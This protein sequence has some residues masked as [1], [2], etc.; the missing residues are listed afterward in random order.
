M[1]QMAHQICCKTPSPWGEMGWMHLF[2]AWQLQ[3]I[4]ATSWIVPEVLCQNTDE[5]QVQK[6]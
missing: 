3:G 5:K 6:L 1:M 4:V 2:D